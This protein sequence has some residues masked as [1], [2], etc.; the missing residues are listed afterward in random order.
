MLTWEEREYAPVSREELYEAVW[1]KPVAH[2]AEKWQVKHYD[3]TRWCKD[4]RIPVPRNGHWQRIRHGISSPKTDLPPLQTTPEKPAV[5][6]LTAP[7]APE[8]T[9]YFG[10]ETGLSFLV[11]DTLQKPDALTLAA[12]RGLQ[13]NKLPDGFVRTNPGQFTIRVSE[14]NKG[15][16]L[17]I[18]DTLIKCWRKR[19]YQIEVTEK[20]TLVWLREVRQRVSLWE[21]STC[22]PN[23]SPTDFRRYLPTGRLAFRMDWFGAK[24][25]RDGTRLLEEQIRDILDHMERSARRLEKEWERDDAGSGQITTVSIT[26]EEEEQLKKPVPLQAIPEPRAILPVGN[27]DFAFQSLLQEAEHW[28]RLKAVDD[29][30]A[31]LYLAVPHSPEFLTWLAQMRQARIENDPLRKRL[32][33]PTTST[34]Y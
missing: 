17:R 15:R 22:P 28:Q 10:G 21:I 1:D 25:W 19:G 27:G 24:Q 11:P 20:H 5:V 31:A 14:S 4:L 12:E 2:L 30:L 34:A 8:E 18:V 9:I 6:N 13:Q 26:E 33:F 32:N 16:A 3:V 29:Y 7:K 23:E